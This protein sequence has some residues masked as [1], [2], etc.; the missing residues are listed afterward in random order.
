MRGK[1]YGTFPEDDGESEWQRLYKPF[2]KHLF[3]VYKNDISARSLIKI[4]Q[5]SIPEKGNNF[6]YFSK[7]RRQEHS[8]QDLS[9]I[10]I[11]FNH[12]S[13]LT[14][15]S[16]HNPVNAVICYEQL[17]LLY[18]SYKAKRDDLITKTEL[19]T[20]TDTIL[21]H[22]ERSIKEFNIWAVTYDEEK[23]GGLNYK[24]LIKPT[25]ID[26]RILI[27]KDFN[28]NR[29]FSEL[30]INGFKIKV[31]AMVSG[32]LCTLFKE[33]AIDNPGFNG[34]HEVDDYCNKHST[35][36]KWAFKKGTNQRKTFSHVFT[37]NEK[38]RG[39]YY[40]I[41]KTLFQQLPGSQGQYILTPDFAQEFTRT[42]SK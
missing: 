26:Q 21:F 3:E 2:Y 23:G 36:K 41:Y 16:C 7:V 22:I 20:E 32:F 13:I 29:D 35:F 25:G 10:K 15:I 31:S 42:H 1:G 17:R 12:K 9:S 33:Y 5:N 28:P 40:L 24:R 6:R 4:D 37:D 19:L 14:S 27:T 39:M 38:G 30:R 34:S 8:Y 11:Q 18:D